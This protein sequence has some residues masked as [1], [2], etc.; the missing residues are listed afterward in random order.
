MA[1]RQDSIR[2]GLDPSSAA[3]WTATP[4]Q[5]SQGRGQARLAVTGADGRL[6][7]GSGRLPLEQ[8][9]G[10]AHAAQEG[11]VARHAVRGEVFR[12]AD[13]G[14]ELLE[15]PRCGGDELLGI[16]VQPFQDSR[17]FARNVAL[18]VLAD[19]PAGGVNEFQIVSFRLQTASVEIASQGLDDIW[20]QVTAFTGQVQLPQY[21]GGFKSGLRNGIAA[22]GT[23]PV[24]HIIQVPDQG[25]PA[26]DG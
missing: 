14:A 23:Q 16:D 3:L 8:S 9:P 12:C 24:Q 19:H 2:Q 25:G 5:D 4:L 11:D 21:T 6:P 1:T 17:G 15:H 10:G 7:R 22:L 26:M 18:L 13:R 20:L